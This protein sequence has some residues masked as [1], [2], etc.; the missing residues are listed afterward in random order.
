MPNSRKRAK[1]HHGASLKR[2]SGVVPK[3]LLEL[4]RFSAVE[5]EIWQARSGDLDE[6]NQ[7]LYFGLEP[8]RLR[9]KD[10]LLRALRKAEGPP[11]TFQNWS[12]IVT[13]EYCLAP[14]SPAGSV[15]SFGGR[16]NIGRDI[17]HA[18]YVSKPALYL[19]SDQETAYREKY[20]LP[21]G[22]LTEGL[23]PEELA[24][25]GRGSSANVRLHGYIKRLIDIRTLESLRPLADVLAKFKVP[26]EALPLIRKLKRPPG[27]PSTLI[28]TAS[29]LQTAL[30]SNWRMLPI[31]FGLPGPTHLFAEMVRE[32]GYEG[33]IYNS[34]KGT[35]CCIAIFPDEL[36]NDE[37]FVEV[38]DPSPEGAI[39]TRLDLENWSLYRGH[40]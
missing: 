2:L 29:A 28:R 21:R 39:L 14:L 13:Y 22:E 32:A 27:S 17:E 18:M 36:S 38:S 24:L 7:I 33:I 16:F 1:R 34:T 12:R 8:Q 19:A 5:L 11:Y 3:G 10:E 26:S 15:R 30:H 9:Y 20:Q 31:Q 4:D 37:S 6:L 25:E 40:C 35:G 23:T